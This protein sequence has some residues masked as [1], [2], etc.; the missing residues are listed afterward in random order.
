MHGGVG[1]DLTDLY[2]ALQLLADMDVHKAGSI[3]QAITS[4]T[5]LA[6][7]WGGVST[8]VDHLWYRGCSDNSFPLLP[9]AYRVEG[10]CETVPL[11][12]FNQNACAYVDTK[13]LDAWDMYFLAQHH[14]IPTRL[15]DWTES[16]IAALYFSMR[17]R[18]ADAT[19]CVWILDPSKLNKYFINYDGL[20]I[21][22]NTPRDSIWLPDAAQEVR[23]SKDTE[24]FEYCNK[25]PLAIWPRRSNKR[26]VAQHGVFTVHGVDRAPLEAGLK[27]EQCVLA[28]IDL[29]LEPENN[30]E[31]LLRA[32][33]LKHSVLFPDL[34]SY[35]KDLQD[36]YKW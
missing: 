15:L 2:E 12:D 14:G 30:I 20:I 11:L 5:E 9:K 32:L 8:P 33:G 4:A 24:R 6:S 19:P 25:T 35:V 26:I 28:R 36:Y 23:R 21:P 17:D 10:Y 31:H 29:H 16:F 27:S 22:S 18:K 34:D 3:A 13:L 7:A 1:E